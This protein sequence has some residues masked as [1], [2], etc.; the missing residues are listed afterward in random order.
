MN[1]GDYNLVDL[2]GEVS[3]GIRH[4]T[5]KRNSSLMGVENRNIFG[6]LY[7]LMN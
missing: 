5:V 6:Q 4:K 1:D 2:E 3:K 7:I